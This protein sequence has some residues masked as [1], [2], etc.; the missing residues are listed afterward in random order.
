[1]TEKLTDEQSRTVIKDLIRSLQINLV[2][3]FDGVE[4]TTR[5]RL[6]RLYDVWRQVSLRRTTD[7]ADGALL[8]FEQNRLV[9]A[10]TLTRSV[11]ETTGVQYYIYRKLITYTEQTKPESVHKFLLSAV[12]G[13]KDK[14]WPE[15]AIQVLTAL[16]HLNKEF[17]GFRDEYDR[18]CEYTHPNL[19]GGYGTYVRP[20]GDQLK[21]YF[22]SNPQRLSMETWGQGSL[23]LVLIA[24]NEIDRQ[25]CLFHPQF[26]SMVEEHAPNTL[27]S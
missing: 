13:R 8:F 14:E 11:F 3:R 4:P 7:L 27:L 15:T 2:D 21:A 20:E 23:R 10:C 26:V 16:D 25:L 1:M 19:S 17:G 22:G 18:L 24:A 9:P 5:Q 6:L 12:F